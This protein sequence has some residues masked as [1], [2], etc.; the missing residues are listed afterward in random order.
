MA[1]EPLFPAPDALEIART[2]W[3]HGDWNS[4]AAMTLQDIQAEPQ[5]ESIC[6]LVGAALGRLGHMAQSRQMIQQALA[7]GCPETLAGRVLLAATHDALG[8]I[9]IMLEMDGEAKAEFAAAVSMTHHPRIAERHAQDRYLGEAAALAAEDIG[10]RLRAQ[11][12]P[13]QIP[14]AGDPRGGRALSGSGSGASGPEGAPGTDSPAP[15]PT[16]GL[17]VPTG[18]AADL[19]AN[20]RFS[21]AAYNRYQNSD[22]QRFLYL[23]TKSLPRSGLHFLKN[24]LADI[25]GRSFSSCE[26]YTEPG[27][28]RTMPCT[29]DYQSR[30]PHVRLLKSHDFDA[31]DPAFPVSGAMQRL[32]LIRDPL[33]LLTSWWTLN[34]LDRNAA[35]LEKHGIRMTKINYHH[36]SSVIAQA[37]DIIE[38]EADLPAVATLESWLEAKQAYVLKFIAKW[39]AAPDGPNHKV[40]IYQDIPHHIPRMLADIAPALPGAA[41]ARL[42]SLQ[43]GHQA[44]FRAR[45]SA[46]SGPVAKISAYLETHARLFHRTAETILALDA[47][48]W[49]G[50]ARERP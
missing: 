8:R 26:W 45:T 3:T 49:L 16:T 13:A 10:I 12:G 15:L 46:F 14:Q 20:P 2:R 37:Y 40:L 23:D 6:L 28:C 47:T 35:L 31:L 4:L 24:S 48:G 7:W 32:I 1:H 18:L 44:S 33:Y 29:L 9:A 25:L 27:C 22:P 34:L 50:R 36:E 42:D 38:A 43:A 17:A 41:R 5:R 11:T 39:G 21:L 30:L 19:Q